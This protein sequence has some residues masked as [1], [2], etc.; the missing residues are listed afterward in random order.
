MDS[1]TI[2]SNEALLARL[3]ADYNDGMMNFH[4]TQGTCPPARAQGGDQQAQTSAYVSHSGRTL[5]NPSTQAWV[6]SADAAKA[7]PAQFENSLAG[8]VR[9]SVDRIRDG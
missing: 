9:L 7:H 6:P 1:T 4:Q 8:S 3:S 2:V 5:L